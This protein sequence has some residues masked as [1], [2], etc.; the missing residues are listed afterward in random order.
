MRFV[1]LD[2]YLQYRKELDKRVAIYFA[3]IIGLVNF[4]FFVFDGVLIGVLWGSFMFLVS[5]SVTYGVRLLANKA[6]DKNREKVSLSG[7]VIDV[8]LKGEF[9]LLSIGQNKIKFVSLQKYGVNKPIDMMV[10]EDLFIGSSRDKHGIIQKLKF[11]KEIK[12]SVVFK[13]MNGGPFYIF[14][15]YDVDGTYDKVVQLL[16]SIRCF[17]PEKYLEK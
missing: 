4:V 1:Q 11:G 17:K 2:R 14:D 12:C 8:T 15:F 7:M 5:F 13:A 16:D 9:G 10:D 6:V 3:S